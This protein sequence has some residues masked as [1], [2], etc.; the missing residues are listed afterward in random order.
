MRDVVH[1]TEMFTLKRLRNRE[2]KGWSCMWHI[3]RD[4]VK[5]YN[6]VCR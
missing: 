4:L 6:K 1:V 2:G 5:V 3:M